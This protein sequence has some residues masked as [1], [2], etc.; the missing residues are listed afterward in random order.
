MDTKESRY[1]EQEKERKEKREWNEMNFHT[2]M[3]VFKDDLIKGNIY[4]PR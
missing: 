3:Q 2:T 4:T 1:Q